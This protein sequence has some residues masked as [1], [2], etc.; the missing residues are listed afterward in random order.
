MSEE[1]ILFV[2]DSKFLLGLN[3]A[4]QIATVL[5]SAQRIGTEWLKDVPSGRN[6][7]VKSP[8]VSSSFVSP[9]T[10]LFRMELDTN[11]KL[12]EAKK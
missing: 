10:A 4:M 11:Q 2:G 7:V 8:D 6:H 3:E 9:M 5:N 12:L 1:F